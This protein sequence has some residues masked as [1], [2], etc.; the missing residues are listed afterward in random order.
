MQTKNFTSGKDNYEVILN[1]ENSLTFGRNGIYKTVKVIELDDNHYDF[2]YQLQKTRIKADGKAEG[3]FDFMKK[4]IEKNFAVYYCR[5]II[6]YA[7]D[8]MKE[9]KN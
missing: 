9:L 5:F 2:I 4:H 3:L 8:S 1:N 6:N 7:I